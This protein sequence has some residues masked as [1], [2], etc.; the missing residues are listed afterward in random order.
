MDELLNKLNNVLG[1]LETRPYSRNERIEEAKFLFSV[2][3]A[4]LQ[5][6]PK[7]ELI[8]QYQSCIVRFNRISHN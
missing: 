6:N 4:N 8:K 2:I 5:K 7:Q 3:K 1:L